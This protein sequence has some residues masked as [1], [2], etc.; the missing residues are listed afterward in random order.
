MVECFDRKPNWLLCKMENFSRWLM[1]LL[2][3]NF[4]IHLLNMKSKEIQYVYSRRLNNW[5]LFL[6]IGTSL[7]ILN[8]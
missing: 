1:I 2:Y 6:G 7:S 8:Y 3:I 4:S 5:I